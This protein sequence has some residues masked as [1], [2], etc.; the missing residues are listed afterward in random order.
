M[1]LVK[2]V[3]SDKNKISS[4]LLILAGFVIG[5][6]NMLAS[7]YNWCETNSDRFII[8]LYIT[9]ACIYLSFVILEKHIS[10][11]QQ[12]VRN[13]FR[14]GAQKENTARIYAPTPTV[15][16]PPGISEE[17]QPIDL[18]GAYKLLSNDNFEGF[19]AVQGVP[20]ALRRAANQA[21]PVHRI[22][23]LGRQLT[24][25]I[26][27]IIESQT[28][29]IINGPPVETDVRG[30]IFEDTVS[31]LEKDGKTTGIV[32]RKKAISEDYDVTVQREL[33]ED[34]QQI[35]MTSTAFFRDGREDIQCVQIFQRVE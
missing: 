6:S 2:S 29:Y 18:S 7:L 19:L 32:V 25:K 1:G 28:T 35:T 21:R 15:A 24:I 23:H 5:K 30:R 17:P 20:W 13:L 26:E 14:F 4:I 33:H 8:P 12:L 9:L 10:R 11:I 16:L 3:S 22:T 34:G 31:Y 27:G